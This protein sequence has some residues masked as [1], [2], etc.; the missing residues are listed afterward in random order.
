MAVFPKIADEMNTADCHNSYR[1]QQPRMHQPRELPVCCTMSY[2]G[3]ERPHRPNRQKQTRHP[4]FRASRFAHPP[5]F[6]QQQ[7]QVIGCTLERVCFAHIG[8]AAQ[9]TP[10]SAAGLA[11]ISKGSVR[12]VHYASD[13][14]AAPCSHARAGDWPGRRLHIRR[15][16][17]SN[18]GSFA[19]V[20]GYMSVPTRRQVCQPAVVVINFV[21][22]HSNT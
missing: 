20:R 17:W 16:C 7:A 10:P 12:N 8:L 1:D 21:H 3:C 9:P 19:V 4:R 13:S 11:D 18:V 5:N 22:H 2:H 14:T 15:V 6:P